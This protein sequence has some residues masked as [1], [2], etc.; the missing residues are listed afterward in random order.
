MAK[1]ASRSGAPEALAPL[2][3][4]LATL[5]L[6]AIAV[7]PAAADGFAL[8]K[9]LVLQLGTAALLIAWLV[10]QLRGGRFEWRPTGGGLLLAGFL[11]AA[12]LSTIFSVSIMTSFLGKP[13][14][15]EGLVSLI[16]YALLYVLGVQI[17][18]GRT[19]RVWIFAQGV[20]LIGAGLSAY[21]LLQFTG[22]DFF[23]WQGLTFE[24][25]RSFAT[26]GNPVLFGG[27]L[28][29]CL[30][31]SIGVFLIQKEPRKMAVYGGAAFLNFAS[32]ITTYTRGSW[33]G[34]AAGL[35]FLFV[36]GRSFILARKK[37]AAM[38]GCAVI[39]ALAIVAV[40]SAGTGRVTDLRSRLASVVQGDASETMRVE[41]W[42]SAVRAIE[43]RPL[44][45]SGPDTFRIVFPR[46]ATR[47]YVSTARYDEVSDN[48]HNYYIQLASTT[49]LPA[50]LLFLAFVLVVLWKGARLSSGGSGAKPVLYAAFGGGMVAYLVYLATGISHH[51]ATALFW[52]MA[53]AV[54]AGVP[55]TEGK[56]ARIRDVKQF[57]QASAWGAGAL[58]VIVGLAPLYFL[59]S[60]YMADLHY[61]NA[62]GLM[63]TGNTGDAVAEFDSAINLRPYSDE[64]RNEKGS[65]LLEIAKNTKDR[66]ALQAAIDSFISAREMNPQEAENWLLLA[67][68]Y[69]YEARVGG[70]HVDDALATLRGSLKLKSLSPVTYY[71]F[72]ECYLLKG[73]KRS[74]KESFSKAVEFKPDFQPAAE[75]LKKL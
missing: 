61:S 50:L 49:G 57:R 64:Y 45:G 62:K 26:M 1:K 15:M 17:F 60:A 6:T 44:V 51:P 36:L 35:L 33:I 18:A 75:Q 28:A 72:G 25:K 65:A 8:P 13:R 16:D 54:M 32:L 12:I 74:A 21:G 2:Y 71:L 39:A 7:S 55:V 19:S 24:A 73:D 29:L 9:A 43:D 69:L 22:L 56:A 30:P 20:A 41:T 42:K 3:I 47:G 67:D 48:A 38:V 37:Q 10:P 59:A 40:A 11:A 27:F 23:A 14:R 63:S 5:V 66:S 34:A 31:V 68:A 52:V 46:Y 58:I 53:A 4:L 70:G